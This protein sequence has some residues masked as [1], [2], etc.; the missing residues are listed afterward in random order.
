MTDI[1]S[2]V[3]E[4]IEKMT[5]TISTQTIDF[6]VLPSEYN[7]ILNRNES[8]VSPVLYTKKKKKN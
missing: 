8:V 1:S 6:K 4:E 5:E 3:E 7:E 2:K